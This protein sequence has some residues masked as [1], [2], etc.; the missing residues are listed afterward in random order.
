M[1]DG[2]IMVPVGLEHLVGSDE[3][4]QS[5]QL[6]SDFLSPVCYASWWEESGLH[7]EGFFSKTFCHL[8]E[9]NK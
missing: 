5:E 4:G 7:K 8:L 3:R 2:A 9:A 6:K 1:F